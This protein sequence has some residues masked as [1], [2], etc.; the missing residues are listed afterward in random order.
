MPFLTLQTF[1][2]STASNSK[3]VFSFSLNVQIVSMKFSTIINERKNAFF[4]HFCPFILAFSFT[5]LV[6]FSKD[7]NVLFQLVLNILFSTILKKPKCHLRCYFFVF[8]GSFWAHFYNIQ[9]TSSSNKTIPFSHKCISFPFFQHF[10]AS[11]NDVFQN[12]TVSFSCLPQEW[13]LQRKEK[14]DSCFR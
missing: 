14:E 8:V 13:K 2:F 3:K 11:F 6:F 12:K 5:F 10:L 9:Y 1:I 4:Y 7:K